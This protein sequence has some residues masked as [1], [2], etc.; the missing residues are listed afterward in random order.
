MKISQLPPD[1]RE[2]ALQRQR[3]EQNPIYNQNS[4]YVFHAFDWE[5]TEEG[6]NTWNGVNNGDFSSFYQFHNITPDKGI[7]KL[8]IETPIDGKL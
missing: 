3:E 1:I 5:D 2:I 8:P 7:L 4:D 6:Y